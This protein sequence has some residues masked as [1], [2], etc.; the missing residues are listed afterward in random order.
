VEGFWNAENTKANNN[1]NNINKK[2]QDSEKRSTVGNNL[3][4]T[5]ALTNLLIKLLM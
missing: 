5:V 3:Q 2:D 4:K 1:N